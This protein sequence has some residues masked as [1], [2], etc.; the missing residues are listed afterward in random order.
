MV[1]W[2]EKCVVKSDAQRSIRRTCLCSKRKGLS[3]SCPLTSICVPCPLCVCVQTNT[4]NN[5]YKLKKTPILEKQKENQSEVTQ[6]K[7]EAWEQFS[8]SYNKRK[9]RNGRCGQEEHSDTQA[10]SGGEGGRAS[11]RG[12]GAREKSLRTGLWEHMR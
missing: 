2:V 7:R 3:P 6:N 11:E 4:C 9:Q 1:Q 8:P 12:R 10:G 5:F